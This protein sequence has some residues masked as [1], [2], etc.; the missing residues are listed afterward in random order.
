MQFN[1]LNKNLSQTVLIS[2][3]LLEQPDLYHLYIDCQLRGLHEI[4][5][6]RE[7]CCALSVGSS[8]TQYGGRLGRDYSCCEGQ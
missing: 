8:L 7:G 5:G 4:V 3:M 1:L 6:E 2:S